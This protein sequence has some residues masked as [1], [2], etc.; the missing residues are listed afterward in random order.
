MRSCFLG[1]DLGSH[2]SKGVL[3]T[4]NG[5]ELASISFEHSTALPNPGWQEQNP[6]IWWE[7]FKKVSKNLIEKSGVNPEEILSV[8]VTGFVPGLVLLDEENRPVRPAIMHTDIRADSQ[9]KYINTLLNSPISH[10]FL[11]PKLLWIMENEKTNYNKINKILVPHGF[12]VERLTGKYSCDID[13]ATI[14]G[15]IYDEEA[16]KWSD[17][18]CSAF[19]IKKNILP[20]LFASN[21]VIGTVSSAASKDTGLLETTQVITG[22]GD[23]F[24][25][26]LG[27]GAVLPGDLM[28]YLGTS[29]T[30]VFVDG[31]LSDFTESRHFGSGKAEFTGRIFSCGDSLEHFKELLGFTDWVIPDGKALEINPGSDGL[32]IFPHLKQKSDTDVSRSDLETIFGLESSHSSWHIYR[33]LLEGIAYN[34]K[35]SFISYEPGVKRVIL[36]GGGAKSKV[37]REIIRDVLGRDVY[38]NPSGNGASGIALLSAYG[39]GYGSGNFSLQNLAESLSKKAVISTPD[40]EAVSKYQKYYKSYKKVQAGLGKLYNEQ[41]TCHGKSQKV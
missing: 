12:I 2:A 16:N 23:T 19:T 39:A 32:Y 34:I 24:S 13:T 25:A 5:I 40:S 29:G 3:V 27:C 9:L 10:G 35:S 28:I 41:E 15:G 31:N 6:E 36:S 37:F 22:T 4:D 18:L 33:A 21:S 38:Y 14:F 11:L 30:Q 17:K 8:G 1:F 7:E 20:N 26:M